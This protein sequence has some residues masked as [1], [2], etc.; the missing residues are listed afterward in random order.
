MRDFCDCAGNYSTVT[1]VLGKAM[2]QSTPAQSAASHVVMHVLRAVDLD[3]V[4]F[5]SN[6]FRATWQNSLQNP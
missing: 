2:R 6:T 3:N 4:V 5:G 1:H